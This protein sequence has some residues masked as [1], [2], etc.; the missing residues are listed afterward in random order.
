MHNGT[1]LRARRYSKGLTLVELAHKSG[2]SRRTIITIETRGGGKP[3]TLTKLAI[4]LGDPFLFL[5]DTARNSSV[6]GDCPRFLLKQI[7]PD[8]TDA[9]QA[10]LREAS[11]AEMTGDFRAARSRFEAALAVPLSRDFEV[12]RAYVTI[13]CA[14]ALDNAGQSREALARLQLLKSS[15]VVHKLSCDIR[16]WADYHIALAYRRLAEVSRN[17]FD[18]NLNLAKEGFETLQKEGNKPQR[19]AATHQL[20]CILLARAL[21][22]PVKHRSALLRRAAKQFEEAAEAWREDANFREGYAIRRRAEIAEIEE[23]WMDAHRRLLDAFEVFA[24]H[25]CFRYQAAVRS[26]LV[27]MMSKTGAR[28]ASNASA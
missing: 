18:M 5:P 15:L 4:A 17:R 10:I 27:S 26:R 21:R 8:T 28:G 14:G 16:N 25:D 13:R 11:V 6:L 3:G 24:R 12:V 22:T 1:T 23:D 20:G 7:F 2:V 9:V 19:I